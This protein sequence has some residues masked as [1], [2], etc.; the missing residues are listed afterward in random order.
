MVFHSDKFIFDGIHSDDL[1]LMLVDTGSTKSVLDKYGLEYK[2]ELQVDHTFGGHPFFAHK[3]NVPEKIKLEFTLVGKDMNPLPWDREME[4]KIVNL[5]MQDKFC[6]FISFDHPELVYYLYGTKVNKTKNAKKEGILE[7]EFQPYYQYP[8]QRY[9]KNL[10]VQG[11]KT[12]ELENPCSINKFQHPITEIEVLE[13]CDFTIRNLSLENS[14]EFKL[15][16]LKKGQTIKVDHSFYI[17]SDE[18]ENNLFHLTNREWLKFKS[19]TNRLKITGNVRIKIHF[20][21]EVRA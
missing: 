11:E 7:V 21:Y 16:G 14:K 10:L 12:T 3:E 20:N 19:G 13:D 5:F 2:E 4:E 17:V 6:E 9:R 8:I 15:S 1:G 18:N